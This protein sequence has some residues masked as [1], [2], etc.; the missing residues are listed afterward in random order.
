MTTVAPEVHR[1]S[2]LRDERAPTA[3]PSASRP[4]AIHVGPSSQRQIT[5]SL[6]FVVTSFLA[7]AWVAAGQPGLP[8][9]FSND[10][11]TI[12]ATLRGTFTEADD[13]FVLIANIYRALGLANSPAI[14][15]VVGVVAYLVAFAFALPGRFTV[16]AR[17][18]DWGI[19]VSCIALAAIY[20][21]AFTKDLITIGVI[22]V[23]LLCRSTGIVSELLPLAAML[24]YAEVFRSYWFLIAGVYLVLRV[25]L[26]LRRGWISTLIAILAIYGVLAVVFPLVVGVD[27]DHYRLLVNE[28]RS[29][30]SVNTII[31]RFV[32]GEGAHI[33][34]ANSVLIFA[35]FIIPLPLV[36]KGGGLYLVVAL[37]LVVVWTSLILAIRAARRRGPDGTWAFTPFQARLLALLLAVLV[38]QSIFEPDYGSFLRHLTPVL[39]IAVALLLSLRHRVAEEPAAA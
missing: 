27:L 39:M 22:A 18:S 11:D 6:I 4:T 31:E 16:A 7:L 15:A 21:G 5:G 30:E 36:I 10:H 29:P 1:R 13:S 25:M 9:R 33:G 32:E 38:V 35:S 26:R 37:L 17:W 19:I 20:H 8:E 12:A 24:L 3:R 14:A 28:F 2:E 34:F 23:V